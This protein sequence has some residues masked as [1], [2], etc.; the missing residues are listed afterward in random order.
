M[1][2]GFKKSI[3][4]NYSSQSYVNSYVQPDMQNN[5]IFLNKYF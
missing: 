5:C 1:Q 2:A 3:V 4:A